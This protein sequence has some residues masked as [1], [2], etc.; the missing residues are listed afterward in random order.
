VLLLGRLV[1]QYVLLLVAGQLHGVDAP[2]EIEVVDSVARS[3]VAERALDCGDDLRGED[4]PVIAEGL[5]DGGRRDE[6]GARLVVSPE[7]DIEL[8]IFV[9][10]SALQRL[11]ASS[12]FA[13]PPSAAWT[14]AAASWQKLP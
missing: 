5:R 7:Q 9:A 1:E 14:C 11:S 12:N 10:R 2:A 13:E 4:E 3:L 6:S 8:I